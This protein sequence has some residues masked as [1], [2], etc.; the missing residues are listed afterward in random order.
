MYTED[1]E[2]V[3]VKNKNSKNDYNDFYTSFSGKDDDEEKKEKGKKKKKE[4]EEE[5][6]EEGD[7]S[8]FYGNEEE[9][10]EEVV[11]KDGKKGKTILKIVI[12][13]LL[14]AI[15]AGLLFVLL[16]KKKETGDIELNNTEITL[17][18]GE[19][20]Y[21]SYRIVGT[22]SDVT[23]TFESS[24]LEVATVSESGEVTAVGNGE[25]I[26]TIKYVINGKTREKQ[27]TVTVNGPEIKHDITLNLKAS[28]T[29]WTNN[30]VTITTEAQSDYGIESIKYAINCSGSC[31]YQDVVDNKI[32]ITDNGSTKVTVIAKDK[33]NQEITKE[34]TAKIDK[35]APNVTYS[36]NK[37]IVSSGE[38]SVCATCS[39]S[40]SGC[41]QS[42]VC[43]KYTSSKSNEVITV[44]DNAGNSKNS[45]TYNVT[46]NKVV[47]PCTLKVASDGT[48]SATLN[49]TA[50]YYGFNSSY[51]GD[52][53]LS[54]KFEM[55]NPGARVVY[56]YVKTKNTTGSCH[57]T[58]IKDSEG[59]YRAG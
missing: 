2:N 49:E 45:T 58:I 42:K 43:K 27:C 53:E 10:E 16:G 23:S 12:I 3:K 44:Y 17:K 7:Y 29:N 8:D 13:I 57:I 52:N 47:Q 18:A 9:T 24:N 32:V 37:D 22:E 4:V 56:Y 33:K 11:E 15:I 36:G 21:I 31:N 54:K 14:I 35:E 46:I 19:T 6:K 38:V 28:T 55:K 5:A 34:I 30:D 40:I 39:D 51:S 48:V 1:D 25:A 26:I 41:K 50:T 20:E 59:K